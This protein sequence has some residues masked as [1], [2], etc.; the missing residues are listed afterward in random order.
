MGCHLWATVSISYFLVSL[1]AQNSWSTADNI[2]H[3]C[4]DKLTAAKLGYPLTSITTISV[5]RAQVST[6]RSQV[7]FEVI[8]RQVTSF[9]MIA[10]SSF[11]FNS[12]E[13]NVL[14]MCCTIKI[15]IS[16]WPRTRKF[17]Q[18]LEAGK[19]VAFDF[20]LHGHFCAL[21]GPNLTGEF[22]QKIYAASSILFC[23]NLWCF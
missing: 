23:V 21:I 18:L 1:G 13:I 19:T 10:G 7:F 14:F 8:R 17:S 20:A 6:H 22:M 16:N 15:L 12:Y 3:Q 2:G 5:S 9:Q 11:F 4:C